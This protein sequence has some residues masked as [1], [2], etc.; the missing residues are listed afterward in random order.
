MD[1][2]VDHGEVGR[3][4]VPALPHEG[5]PEPVDD[6]LIFNFRSRVKNVLSEMDPRL[7]SCYVTLEKHAHIG[8]W[9][10]NYLLDAHGVYTNFFDAE[11]SKNI[12]LGVDGQGSID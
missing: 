7:G 10:V 2:C 3:L 9:E 5:E 4:I 11:L 8:G 1:L 12:H 6:W